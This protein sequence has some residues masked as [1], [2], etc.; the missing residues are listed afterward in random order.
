LP[1]VAV[2]AA[3]V[4]A[5]VGVS[6]EDRV[7]VVDEILPAVFGISAELDDLIKGFKAAHLSFLFQQ[8]GK[9]VV[10]VEQAVPVNLATAASGAVMA[11]MA[12]ILALMEP[13]DS[14]AAAVAAEVILAEAEAG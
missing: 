10:A 11:V 5:Q 2:A 8:I 9:A 12:S 1:L 3:V 7:A 6:L 14:M 13:Y 4:L